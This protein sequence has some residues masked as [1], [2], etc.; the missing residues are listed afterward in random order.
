MRMESVDNQEAQKPMTVEEVANEVISRLGD[1]DIDCIRHRPSSSSMH[2][3]LGLWIRNE[4]IYSRKMGSA[5]EPDSV[6]S[7]ITQLIAS[8]LLPEYA[9]FPLVVALFDQSRSTFTSAHRYY[10]DRDLSKMID[11]IRA[12]YE[13]L[14]KAEEK[15]ESIKETIDWSSED[16]SE[17]W[18]TAWKERRDCNDTFKEHIIRDLFDEE[19]IEE[20]R[21]CENETISSR[22][23]DI[24]RFKDCALET[25]SIHTTFFVPAEIAY[26]ADS[27]L[28][29][30]PKWER[31]KDALL[32][33]VGEIDFYYD[34]EPLPSWLF[35]DDEIA[36]AAL[37]INGNFIKYMGDRRSDL[38][39][40]IEALHSAWPSYKYIDKDLM[41]DR[42]AIKAALSCNRCLSVLSEDAF[43]KYNDDDELVALALRSEG[44]NLSWSSE[45]IRDDF[46][47]VCLAI[48][49]CSYVDNIYKDISE[50]LRGDRRIV[51][52][53]ASRP[54]VPMEF[55]PAEFK[56]D[57]EIGAL[58]ADTEIHGSHFALFG[59]SRRIKEKYMTE[60]ELDRWGDGDDDEEGFE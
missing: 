56:D 26:L 22:L 23:D 24:I 28:K 49:N 57:D 4:Y 31:G 5:G 7:K 29:G 15:L 55:P 13:P 37:R 9:E 25:V 41:E 46:D 6:S 21:N 52:R 18:H 11:A 54:A 60:D 34:G 45:R 3:G 19:L 35:D 53:I 16:H 27:K 44:E 36:L 32:W 10:L 14:A 1:Q 58:L 33:L 40:A 20:L 17:I 12:H 43:C 39:S 50:R 2:F 8:K 47:M 30:S 59:M 48:E 42:E 51:E 38:S